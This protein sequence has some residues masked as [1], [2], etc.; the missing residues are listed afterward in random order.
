[1][2]NQQAASIRSSCQAREDASLDELLGAL[3]GGQRQRI[4]IARALLLDTRI[5]ILDEATSS[6]DSE[7][8]RLVQEALEKYARW[9]WSCFCSNQSIGF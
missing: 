9:I 8:E 7:S 5:V 6:L 3:A 4:A 2:C 1:M